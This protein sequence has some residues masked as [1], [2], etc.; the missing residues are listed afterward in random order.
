[1]GPSNQWRRPDITLKYVL[2]D[3]LNLI[4]KVRELNELLNKL[5]VDYFNVEYRLNREMGV[6]EEITD[7]KDRHRLNHNHGMLTKQGT[8]ISNLKTKAIETA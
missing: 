6:E 8:Q 5:R 7:E 4:S 3:P 2:T 1:M